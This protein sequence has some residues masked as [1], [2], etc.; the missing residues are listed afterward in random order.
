MQGRRKPILEHFKQAFAVAG[1]IPF[2]PSSSDRFVEQDLLTAMNAAAANAPLFIDAYDTASNGLHMQDPTLGLPDDPYL[3]QLLA[4]Y[5][6][7]YWIDRPHLRAI[8]PSTSIPLAPALPSLDEQARDLVLSTLERSSIALAEGKGLEAVQTVLWLLETV[9]TAFRDPLLP[10][11]SVQQ[12]YFNK[13]V[14]ALRD[15]GSV[16]GHQDQILEWMMRLHGYLS[17]PTG[18]GVRH[19]IDLAHGRPLDLDEATLFCNLIRS[20]LIYLVA[21]H[22][23]LSRPA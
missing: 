10:G 18:G 17:S 19:G 7:G 8:G 15:K 23:R 5:A 9:S 12:A 21:E 4:Q 20:Y 2:Y 22:E 11:G 1:A 14:Q 16:N 3:N 6:V 13:I